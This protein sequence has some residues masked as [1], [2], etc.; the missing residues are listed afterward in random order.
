MLQS[1]PI[2]DMKAPVSASKPPSTPSQSR[3]SPSTAATA[4]PQVMI[5]GPSPNVPT[6]LQKQSPKKVQQKR[7]SSQQSVEKPTKSNKNP[8]D[9]QVLL[10]ALADE[11]LNTA[12]CHGTKMALATRQADIEE[13][14]KL[15]ATGLG[16]L[17]AVLKVC[18]PCLWLEYSS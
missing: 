5:P 17:E 12:H 13:Y 1:S 2:V 7:Q 8:V 11:Y 14:Y 10:L 18:I 9:Y 4:L 16:C 3:P 15:V 6:N